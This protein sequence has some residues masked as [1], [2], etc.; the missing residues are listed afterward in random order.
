MSD[1]YVTLKDNN[2]Y[3]YPEG[4][5]MDPNN[6]LA[7]V[8]DTETYL[9]NCIVTATE[10][11]YCMFTGGYYAQRFIDDVE[12]GSKDLPI[13]FLKKGQ[14]VYQYNLDRDSTHTI[15]LYGLKRHS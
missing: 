5:G 1:K 6:L 9:R 11:C 13:F 3:I 8:S 15:S 12:F 10:D 4:Y 7:S 14:T 2:D